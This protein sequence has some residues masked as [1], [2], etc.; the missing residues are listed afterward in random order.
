[1][2]NLKTIAGV[3]FGVILYDPP[4]KCA[5][6]GTVATKTRHRDPKLDPFQGFSIWYFRIPGQKTKINNEYIFS[7][8]VCDIW[9]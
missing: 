3:F 8:F 4:P 2:S 6:N 5:L 1:M 9:Q 7:T